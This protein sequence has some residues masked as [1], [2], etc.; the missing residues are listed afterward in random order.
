[1]RCGGDDGGGCQGTERH[2]EVS[3]RD[4]VAA[5]TWLER[6]RGAHWGGGTH[7]EVAGRGGLSSSGMGMDTDLS[8]AD[9]PMVSPASFSASGG[10]GVPSPHCWLVVM[11]DPS[12]SWPQPCAR[13]RFCGEVL[14]DDVGD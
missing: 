12:S 6:P 2:P 13:P 4:V 14:R 7:P 9:V 10:V 1:M 11:G 5:G 8:V 3:K